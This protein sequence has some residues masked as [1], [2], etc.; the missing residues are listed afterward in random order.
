MKHIHILWFGVFLCAT[1]APGPAATEE[2]DKAVLVQVNGVP[3]TRAQVLERVFRQYG[4]SVLNE[5]A[6][7]ILVRREAERLAVKADAREVQAGL[8]RIRDQFKDEATFKERLTATGTNPEEI[9][10]R[11]EEQVVRE[12]LVAK[13]RNIKVTESEARDFFEA[14]RERLGAPESVRLRHIL[15]AT[16]REANDFMVALRAGGADFAKLASQASQDAGSREKG[17]DLGFVSRGLLLPEIEKAAFALKSGEVAGPVRTQLG[18]HIFKAEEVLAAKPAVFKE[19]KQDLVKALEAE[20][21][22]KAW[23][24]YLQ[25]LRRKGKYEPPAQPAQASSR[26]PWSD[27]R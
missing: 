10:A 12:A 1:A 4:T 24:D 8:K 9:R 11:I 25:E 18:F 22:A 13:A 14:N 3:I 16:E 20:R 19:I 27:R 5:M 6:D 26:P 2:G 21:I 23:P 17:G 7:D 15:V